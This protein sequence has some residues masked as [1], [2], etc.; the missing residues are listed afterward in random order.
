MAGPTTGIAT[1]LLGGY[2]SGLV[3]WKT[4]W[5]GRDSTHVRR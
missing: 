5:I 2:T 4:F 1:M 3:A